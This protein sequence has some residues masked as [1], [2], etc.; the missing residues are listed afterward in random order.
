MSASVTTFTDEGARAAHDIKHA[1]PDTGWSSCRSLTPRTV[2]GA[3]SPC[4][5]MSASPRGPTD[6]HDRPPA[7]QGAPRRLLRLS[8]VRRAL[9]TA[10]V[11]VAAGLLVAGMVVVW[12]DDLLLNPSDWATTSTRLIANPTIRTSTATYLA[13]EIDARLHLSQ[14]LGSGQGSVLGPLAGPSVAATRA[15]IFHAVDTALGLS[16]VRALWAQANRAAAATA[17][18]IVDGRRGPVTVAGGAVTINLGPIL[19]AVATAAHL[20]AAVTATLPANAATLTVVQSD[21]VHTVQTAGRAVR[22]LARWLVIVVPVLWLAALALARRRR[23]RTLVWIGITGAVA[24][25]LVL[26]SRALLAAPV[27]DAISADPSLRR[28]I[29]AA[30]T[31]ITTSLGHLAVGV[32]VVGLIVGVI[33]GLA[34]LRAGH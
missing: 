24:G 16:P 22:A 29:A 26:G 28:V 17:V 30:I 4:S 15:T 31:T 2:T 18:T 20:P 6:P 5:P 32:G 33:A 3:Y 1:Q 11:G 21:R 19:R 34:G 7:W 12:A 27:A 13:G 10:L 14:L 25:T 8:P 9:I 23:R